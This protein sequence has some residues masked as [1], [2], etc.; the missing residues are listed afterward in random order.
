MENVFWFLRE[1]LS[2]LSIPFE[3]G[4]WPLAISFVAVLFYRPIYKF[5]TGVRSIKGPGGWEVTI[6]R[7]AV[8]SDMAVI[9]P[10]EGRERLLG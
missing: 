4:S 6:E 3:K 9:K 7:Q 1:L 5:I 8:V 2:I 10:A